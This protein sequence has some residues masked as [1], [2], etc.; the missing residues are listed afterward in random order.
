MVET[1]IMCK[2]GNKHGAANVYHKETFRITKIVQVS[3]MKVHFQIAERSLF[4]LNPDIQHRRMTYPPERGYHTIRIF[5]LPF[6][7][8][9]D[10]LLCNVNYILKTIRRKETIFRRIT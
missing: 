5:P 8:E 2:N 1:Y 9:G 3:A 6:D 7:W 10:F 4:Y